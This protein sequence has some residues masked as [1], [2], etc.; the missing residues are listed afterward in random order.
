M[1]RQKT[2]GYTRISEAVEK[3][4]LKG[5]QLDPGD[6]LSYSEIN[7]FIGLNVLSDR[8]ILTRARTQ[9][10][11]HGIYFDS[12]R[13]YGIQMATSL[14]N[15]YDSSRQAVSVARRAKKTILRLQST[16]VVQLSKNDQ[17]SVA[18]HLGLWG[19]IGHSAMTMAKQAAPKPQRETST[20]NV[21]PELAAYL[22][23]GQARKVS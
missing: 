6:S 4:V 13:G 10:A 12:V 15:K 11:K 23:Y 22:G 17:T 9:W 21:T 1:R 5:L 18:N 2:E 3:L 7:N 19:F 16:D 20:Q 14:D 8:S